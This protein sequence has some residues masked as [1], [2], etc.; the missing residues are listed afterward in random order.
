MNEGSPG[1]ANADGRLAAAGPVA[2]EAQEA[3][4]IRCQCDG[5]DDDVDVAVVA[6]VLVY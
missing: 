4:H 2:S 5:D 6:V 1:E 3:R